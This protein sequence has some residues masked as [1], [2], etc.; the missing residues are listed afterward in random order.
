MTALLTHK[1]FC[2]PSKHS[3]IFALSPNMQK[4]KHIF[5]H[6]YPLENIVHSLEIK[7]H[8]PDISDKASRIHQNVRSHCDIRVR[9]KYRDTDE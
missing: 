7:F 5:L 2:S 8:L 6:M 1:A 3:L 9:L 4:A